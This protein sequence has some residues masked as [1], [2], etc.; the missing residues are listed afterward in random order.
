MINAVFDETYDQHEAP[1]G[2]DAGK[3]LQNCIVGRGNIVQAAAAGHHGHGK[4]LQEIATQG[5]ADEA[6]EHVTEKSKAVFFGGRRGKKR[7]EN[8]RDNLNDKIG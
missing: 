8:A 6:Y 1:A 2:R 5:A 4:R 3:A 7:T